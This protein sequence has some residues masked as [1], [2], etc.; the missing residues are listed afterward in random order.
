MTET[1]FYVV[2]RD[3]SEEYKESEKPAIDQLIAMGYQYKSQRELN[4]E[5]KDY[6]QILLYNRLEHA[7][8]KLN[9]EVDEDGVYDALD[10]IKEENF[11]T[12]LDPMDLNE[13]IRAKLVGLSRTGGLD[14]ITVV[15]N[16]GEGNIDKT[17]RLFDFDNPENNDFLI[18]NQ[19]QL[20]GLKEPIY[21]DIVVFVNGIPLVVLECKSPNIRNPIQE[22]VEKNFARYQSRGHGY[23]RLMFFNHFLI[24]TC[25]I[26]SR[27]G[28]IGSTVNHY[29]RWSEAHPLT[30]EDIQ[31][32][33]KRKQPRE[34]EILIAG[35]L[36]KK[37]IL[38]LLKNY[39]IYEVSNNKKIKKIAK[40]QQYRVVTKAVEKLELDQRKNNVTDK[41]GVIWHTQGSGKSL[42]MLWLAT[43]LMYKFGNPPILLVTD[44]KQLDE[45]IHKTFKACGFPTPIRANS[46]KDLEKLL[47]SPRGKTIMTTIQKFGMQ[48]GLIHTKEKVIVLIDEGHR[49]Q[50]KF[51]AEAM[52]VAIPNGVF[53]AFT[54]TPI[55]KKNKSTYKVFGPLLDRYS[56]E[57]SKADGATLPIM[58][59][60]RL[61]E[62]FVEGEDETIEQVFDRVF[63]HL[64]KDDKDKLKK[65]YITKEKIN[66][67]PAR[68]RK[69]C[70]DLIEHFTREIRPN[71]YKA[72]IVA[73][74]R[75][76]AITYKRELDK[77]NGPLSKIIM[78]SRLGE[79]G[80]D[81]SS[82]DEYFLSNEQREKET[83]WFKSPEDPTQI[84]IVVDMLLVGY[85]APIVQ[86]LYLDKGLREHTLLQAIARVN[87][88]YNAGKQFG[89]IID[90]CGI[91]NELQEALALFDEK[92]I[93]DV[94]V[95]FEN[96]VTELRIRAKEA[97]AYFSDLED[98][99]DNTEIIAKFEPINIRDDFEYAFKMF[100][101]AMDA[102]LPRKEANPY[103]EDLKFLSQKRQMLR[104]FYGGVQTSLKEDGKK[105]QQ[106]I[107]D[108]IRSLK[109]SQLMEVREVTD[110]TFLSDIAKITKNNKKTQTALIKNK[111]TQIIATKAHQNP[112]YY[113]KMKERLDNLIK[114][115]Q[116]ARKEEADYFNGYKKILQELLDEEN[117]RKKLGFSNMFEFAVYEE[118]LKV[119]KDKENSKDFTKKISK[120][121][122]KETELVGWKTKTSSEKQLSIIIYD[123]LSEFPNK[124]LADNS[125]KKDLM[126]DHFIDLAK[127]NL[128][129]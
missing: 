45:Q 36:N 6:R 49:T 94:L 96:E 66:E 80:K 11:P 13:Q 1:P 93:V 106:L 4:V 102:V 83:T 124:K 118:L 125:E 88:P 29:A 82:W 57:E 101:K 39:V 110:E 47:K 20:E 28:S 116:E 62:L 21:P 65:Q 92:D 15:Q 43:Q 60:G 52:R 8:R 107:D 91:T 71:G 54:G 5:R 61:S 111:A 3:E 34:Q 42:S 87:R 97:M 100:S 81:G 99:N 41:G 128:K 58:Y 22:A 7:I 103:I 51:N 16:F 117:E 67:A 63:S 127:R 77:L 90:Y 56:F 78:T 19:F 112:V 44:R 74:S 115:E 105:V 9:P 84:L 122:K 70:I 53:F 35:M 23:E 72:M 95:P 79:K 50:Y 85:D 86:V 17:I 59:E 26:L 32:L 18:T 46:S 27:H 40:H 12:N 2:G 48:D 37:H 38:D 114:E 104:N 123:I 64:M 113:E 55:D 109:I 25:G 33:T 76:A 73:S 69:I 129:S 14:P 10:Q 108:H 89:L 120:G 98:K 31:K 126:T 121:I 75:E 24:A 68:I 119:T 30:L